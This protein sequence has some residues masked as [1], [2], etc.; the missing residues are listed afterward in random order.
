[1]PGNYSMGLICKICEDK[2][3]IETVWRKVIEAIMAA[4][5]AFSLNPLC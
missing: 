1:M 5:T 4:L 2:W 3:G